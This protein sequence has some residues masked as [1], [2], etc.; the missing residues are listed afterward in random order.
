MDKNLLHGT[1][2]ALITPIKDG[3]INFLDFSTLLDMQ[4]K[5]GVDGVVPCG[6]TGE[7][8]TLKEHEHLQ[9][10]K[11][12]IGQIAGKIPVIAGTGAN[13]TEEALNLTQKADQLGADAFLLVAPYYNKPSQEGLFVHFSKNC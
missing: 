11:E 3:S 5:G 4:L 7:S 10:I 13:S 9:V 8:P 12:T 1:H 6:T 2:T